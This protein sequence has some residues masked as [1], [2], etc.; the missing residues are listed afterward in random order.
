MFQKSSAY[1]AALWLR[2]RINVYLSDSAIYSPSLTRP[3]FGGARER[4]FN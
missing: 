3:R 1:C 4:N 2:L